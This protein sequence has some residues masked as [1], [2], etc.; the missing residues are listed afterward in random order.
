MTAT[1][2]IACTALLC[3]LA[4]AA[5]AEE[6][7]IV[8]STANGQ[9]GM[10]KSDLQGLLKGDTKSWPG[11]ELVEIVLQQT[12]APENKWL[13]EAAFGVTEAMLLTRLGQEVFKGE[14][15]QP[16]VVDSPAACLAEVKKS[17]RAFCAVPAS[18]AT[19][20]PAGVSVFSVKG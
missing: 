9:A 11:G 10:T 2:W 3:A 7:V 6:F 15:R 17:K 13:A 4:G 14:L 8:T 1:K 19:P 5:R 12:G 16:K 18:A 20:A